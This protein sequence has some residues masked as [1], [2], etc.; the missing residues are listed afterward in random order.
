VRLLLLAQ[1]LADVEAMYGKGLVANC[2]LV[3]FRPNSADEADRVSRMVGEAIEEQL[4]GG[5]IL[6]DKL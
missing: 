2:R 4:R 3:V 6:F 1:S 5:V